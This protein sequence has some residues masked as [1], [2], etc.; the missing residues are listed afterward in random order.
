V[1]HYREYE[2]DD[3]DDDG[4]FVSVYEGDDDGL[5]VSVPGCHGDP[6]EK[7]YWDDDFCVKPPTSNTVV[8]MADRE[9]EVGMEN[10]P[11]GMC[12]GDCWDNDDCQGDLQCFY[13]EEWGDAPPGCIGNAEDDYSYCYSP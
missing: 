12:Q 9:G 3:D 11:L 13:V 2:G 10:Y 5:V 7:E 1:C 8:I 6:L 4:L